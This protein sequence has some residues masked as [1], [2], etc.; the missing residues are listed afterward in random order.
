MQRKH[1]R[2]SYKTLN[3]KLGQTNLVI[4]I[5]Q[6]FSNKKINYLLNQGG[7]LMY[8]QLDVWRST[9]NC[10]QQEQVAV[11]PQQQQQ[12]QQQHSDLSMIQ[13]GSG[14]FDPRI[15]LIDLMSIVEDN[16]ENRSFES[17]SRSFD[18]SQQHLL[19]PPP[20]YPG[21][22]LDDLNTDFSMEDDG[23]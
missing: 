4:L 20:A 21:T 10:N 17:G 7:D 8:S 3:H 11:V 13:S 23:N 18:S 9:A 5:Q 12:Q 14:Q 15:N 1:I 6:G 22:P 16:N 2:T 19:E